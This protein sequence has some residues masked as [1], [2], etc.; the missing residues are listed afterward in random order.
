M[1]ICHTCQHGYSDDVEFCPRDG[2]QLTA[3]ATETEAQL[4]VQLSR[5]FRIVRRLGAGDMSAAFLTEQIAVGNR[6]VAH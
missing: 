2:A 1:K 4:A 3:Q 5:R 6:L